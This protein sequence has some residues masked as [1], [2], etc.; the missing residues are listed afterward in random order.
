LNLYSHI[1]KSDKK[2]QN[3]K[4][5]NTRK[6]GRLKMREEKTKAILRRGVAKRDEVDDSDSNSTS[7]R[8]M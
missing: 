1:T 3:E 7:T 5:R 2:H 6:S 8:H 4:K